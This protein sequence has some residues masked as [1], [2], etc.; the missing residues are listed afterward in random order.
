MAPGTDPY[1][2]LVYAAR[3]TDVRTTV[4]DGEILVR[5]FALTQLDAVAITIEARAA[6]RR[7]IDR[8]G[9]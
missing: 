1:S 2:M 9:I 7:L 3:G 8:A 4:V 6:A 5:D